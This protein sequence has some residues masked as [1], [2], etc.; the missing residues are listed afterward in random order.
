MERDDEIVRTL[1]AA[2]CEIEDIR[3]QSVYNCHLNCPILST[4]ENYKTHRTLLP[5]KIN[6]FESETN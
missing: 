3:L 4:G 2:F 1:M 5:K 6:N